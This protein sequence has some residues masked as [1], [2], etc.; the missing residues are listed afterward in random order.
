[1]K[2]VIAAGGTGTYGLTVGFLGT[3]HMGFATA[4]Q[5][6]CGPVSYA[7][8][9]VGTLTVDI[10]RTYGNF[11]PASVQA[12]TVEGTARAGTDFSPVAMTVNF[13]HGETRKS[14]TIPIL[15]DT[16]PEGIE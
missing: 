7:S 12:T 15:D 1:M 14:V 6:A 4:V 3:G 11:G 2:V 5:R 9:S 10:V 13:A 8:E 16:V